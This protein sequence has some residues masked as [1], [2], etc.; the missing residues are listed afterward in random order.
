ML[1]GV[2]DVKWEVSFGAGCI[3]LLFFFSG[4][5]GPF[6]SQAWPLPGEC[7]WAHGWYLSGTR[8]LGRG[9][10]VGGQLWRLWVVSPSRRCWIQGIPIRGVT[11]IKCWIQLSHNCEVMFD[12]VR[13]WAERAELLHC[14]RRGQLHQ[15]GFC[16]CLQRT[17]TFWVTPYQECHAMSRYLHQFE[18]CTGCQLNLC[19][20]SLDRFS[21]MSEIVPGVLRSDSHG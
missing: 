10:T 5:S 21:K 4:H 18:L 9:G 14:S 8:V 13:L 1:E 20:S 3:R 2:W 15:F 16:L 17:A 11:W 12:D 6:R 7:Q 19:P